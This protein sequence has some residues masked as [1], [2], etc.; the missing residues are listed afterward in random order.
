MSL[1]LKD[2]PRVKTITKEDF[3]KHYFKPQK[4]VV[5]EHF[6]DHWPAYKKWNLDY[7]KTAGS[8]ITVPL[9]DDR[10]VDYKD[11]FNQP[12]AKMKLGDY[13]DL[14]KHEPTKYRIF[15]WNAIK[16][17]PQLQQDFSFPNFGLRLMKGIPMLFFG[18]RD[19]YT[20]MH[21]DIDLA[22]IFHFHFEGKKQIILFDQKQSKYLYKIPHSLITREDIDFA[23]PDFDKW[24]MLKN[25]VGYQTELN[26][27]EV[28]YMPEGYWH[29]M[30]YITPGFSMSLRAIARNPKNFSKALYNLVI[31]RHFDN[32]MRRI[33]GQKWIDWKNQQAI[34]KTHKN[35]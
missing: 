1:N 31:M 3:L 2:I 33:K 7:M 10:P 16:E 8:E 20:F 18:G 32:T 27:G 35:L 24:P 17:I 21:Y 4:P 6:I 26:H 9:Y 19:S 30:R 34:T 23:N 25:A 28:L 15:L 12:H 13:I 14:L 11:G 22:N 5:I 29:Y